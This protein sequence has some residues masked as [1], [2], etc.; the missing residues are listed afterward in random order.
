M[1][2]IVL[3]VEYKEEGKAQKVQQPVYYINEVLSESTMC[4]LHY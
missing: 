4:Y 3:M 2:I 1:V